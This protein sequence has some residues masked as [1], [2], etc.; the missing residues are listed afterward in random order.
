MSLCDPK[1]GTHNIHI[2]ISLSLV[3]RNVAEVNCCKLR[4]HKE[5]TVISQAVSPHKLLQ[6]KPRD[7]RNAWTAPSP[8]PPACS[9]SRPLLVSSFPPSSNPGFHLGAE[10]RATVCMHWSWPISLLIRQVKKRKKRKKRKSR[11]GAAI[12]ATWSWLSR[13]LRWRRKLREK[14]RGKRKR[15]D[16]GERE[17]ERGVSTR[18]SK[19]SGPLF[20]LFTW[21]NWASTGNRNEW[22]L[23]FEL[24]RVRWPPL[25]DRLGDT[26]LEQRKNGRCN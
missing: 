25:N 10:R 23:D 19:R 13:P 11:E 2:Y 12:P 3:P 20:S 7:E 5:P 16:K 1:R 8:S 21:L 4:L 14:K 26:Y 18:W 17:R 6:T 9:L 24:T 15:E 22:A